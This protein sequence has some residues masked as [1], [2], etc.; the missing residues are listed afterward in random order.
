V[1]TVRF[2][3][4]GRR[5]IRRL[6]PRV[7]AGASWVCLCGTV[8]AWLTL[9][10]GDAWA[11]ATVLLF[12]PRWVLALGPA[13][14]LV[15]AWF[16]RRRAFV[17]ATA[18]LVVALGPVMGFNLPWAR[19]GPEPGGGPRLRVLT[20]NLHYTRDASA[21][22][23]YVAEVAP[24]VVAIQEWHDRP[25]PPG[26]AWA[27]W[28]VHREPG[29]FLASRFPLTAAERLGTDSNRE[30]GSAARYIV[31]TPQGPVTVFSLHLASPRQELVGVVAGRDGAFRAGD[32]LSS[33]GARRDS[34]LPPA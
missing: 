21:L 11:P 12:G 34:G 28:H 16:A 18:A 25:G 24:D 8:V 29:L 22:E 17:A 27:G 33:N 2:P 5:P 10:A 9:Y 4:A 15:P 32:G 26:P 23:A 19:L 30:G 1:S 7:I 6:W 20:C 14:L 3:I 13:V 31:E